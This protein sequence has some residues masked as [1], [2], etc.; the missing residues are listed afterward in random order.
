MDDAQLHTVWQQRQLHDS[1][2]PLSQPLHDLLKHTLSKR[3]RQLHQLAGVWD[4]VIPESIREHTAMEGLQRGVLTVVVD[5]AAH[6]FQL[7]TLLAGGLLKEIQAR[8]S[9]VLQ[10]I[11]IVPGQ[12]YSVDLA[13][14]R[15]YGL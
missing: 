10:K 7:Q 6:R 13:G 12:F 2:S 5:S 15:R 3:F 14:D 9:G 8:F 1:I 11:R 4:E